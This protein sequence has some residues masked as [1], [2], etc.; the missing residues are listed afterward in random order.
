MDGHA[1]PALVFF[2]S[3]GTCWDHSGSVDVQMLLAALALWRLLKMTTVVGAA[4]SIRL[5][6]AITGR[7]G[8]RPLGLEWRGDRS[9][10][11]INGGR[12]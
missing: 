5:L 9:S 3:S 6:L 11:M 1:S 4:K 2:F 10:H 8:V 7:Y 12:E